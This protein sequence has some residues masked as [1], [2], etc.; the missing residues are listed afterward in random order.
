[1]EAAGGGKAAAGAQIKQVGGS[2]PPNNFMHKNEDSRL[3][4]DT[5]KDNNSIKSRRSLAKLQRVAGFSGGE[6]PSVPV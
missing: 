1:M 3:A 5:R 2:K 4:Q 6:P